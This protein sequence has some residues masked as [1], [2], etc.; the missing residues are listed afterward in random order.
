MQFD[1][2]RSIGRKIAAA[3]AS[4]VGP[5]IGVYETDVFGDAGGCPEGF[6]TVDFRTGR[7]SGG[8][9]SPSLSRAI[10]LYRDGL[11]DL[12]VKH[13]TSPSAFREREMPILQK[14]RCDRVASSISRPICGGSVVAL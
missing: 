10:K 13:S 2:P 9:S 3:L 5:P 14:V 8:R 7:S 11:T 1:A 6:I 4:G 12:C